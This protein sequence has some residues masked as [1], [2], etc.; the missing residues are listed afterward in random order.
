[1]SAYFF[2]GSTQPRG[3]G[4][5]YAFYGKLCK[6]LPSGNLLFWWVWVGR[7]CFLRR[8]PVP[9]P[10]ARR[11]PP[12]ARS[13]GPRSLADRLYFAGTDRAA[14]PNQKATCCSWFCFRP[15]GELFLSVERG[16]CCCCCGGYGCCALTTH[17]HNH[18]QS[19]EESTRTP[20]CT[21][22]HARQTSRHPH[23]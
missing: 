16:Y 7:P 8:G 17:A 19:H 11:P 12:G 23:W 21:R 22:A 3:A 15:A 5:G 2:R 4:G 9:G 18:T 20:P 6:I 13:L 1:M 14:S 10:S